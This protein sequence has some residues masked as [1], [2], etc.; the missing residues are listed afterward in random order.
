MRGCPS[1]RELPRSSLQLSPLVADGDAKSACRRSR[2]PTSLSRSLIVRS[3]TGGGGSANGAGTGAGDSVLASTRGSCCC[4][5]VPGDHTASMM[6]LKAER[7]GVEVV[8]SCETRL[9]DADDPAATIVAISASFAS[10]ISVRFFFRRAALRSHCFCFLAL[11]CSAVVAED[12]PWRGGAVTRGPL[13]RCG[14][15][16]AST[17]CNP[18]PF[19]PFPLREVRDALD[20][21]NLRVG[22]W[23]ARAW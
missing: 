12:E 17:P 16:S 11:G 15:G 19:P 8:G 21:F 3:A 20:I 1:P 2:L 23:A 9:A 14:R 13:L 5:A 22:E 7:M 4:N 10:R 18:K 6:R